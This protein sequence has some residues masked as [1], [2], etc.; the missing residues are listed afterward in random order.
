M[1]QSVRVLDSCLNNVRAFD[2]SQF[3]ASRDDR[4]AAIV[5]S[6]IGEIGQRLNEWAMVLTICRGAGLWVPAGMKPVSLAL[7]FSSG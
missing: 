4:G 1:N 2:P 7:Y 3:M 5:R 6:Q